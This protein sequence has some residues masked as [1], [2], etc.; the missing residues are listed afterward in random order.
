MG[1]PCE[2]ARVCVTCVRPSCSKR[3]LVQLRSHERVLRAHAQ[4]ESVTSVSAAHV[5]SLLSRSSLW[6]KRYAR[7]DTSAGS[8][9]VCWQKRLPRACFPPLGGPPRGGLPTRVPGALTSHAQRF[10]SGGELCLFLPPVRI[11]DAYVRREGAQPHARPR[12][13]PQ[14]DWCIRD[15]WFGAEATQ[16]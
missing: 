3:D 6:C 11:W 9:G 12:Q 2:S 10:V 13:R 14:G 1:S 5:N 16:Q 8:P 7:A 4:T 15:A